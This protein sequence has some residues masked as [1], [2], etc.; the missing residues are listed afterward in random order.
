M[1]DI[2]EVVENPAAFTEEERAE[3]I[4]ILNELIEEA[5]NEVEEFKFDLSRKSAADADAAK[6]E[7]MRKQLQ[8][9]Q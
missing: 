9:F 5:I 7:E 4:A 1:V 3:A 2:F 6:L 8:N